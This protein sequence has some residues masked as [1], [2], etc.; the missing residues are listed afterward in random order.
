MMTVMRVV[1]DTPPPIIQKRNAPSIADEVAEA[2]QEVKSSG[3]PLGTT[4]SEIDRIIASVVPQRD[5]E[6]V[7]AAKTSTSKM[8]N[9]KKVS[10]ESK[11]FDLRHLGGQQL[12]EED[13][14]ELKEFDISGGYQPRSV[15]FGGVNEEILGCIHDRAGVKVVN[16]LTR[17]I[18]FPK[19]ERDLID[20]R[21]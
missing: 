12:F 1:L 13:I 8:K 2:P 11:I 6:E 15:L 17:S 14:S 7:V 4:L 18:G 21:K 20:Y 3:G 16:T 9:T 19:L 5:T 10:S